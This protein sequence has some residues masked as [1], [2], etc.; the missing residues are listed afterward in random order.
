MASQKARQEIIVHEILLPLSVLF[1][2]GLGMFPLVLGQD[3][4]S[5][6]VILAAHILGQSPVGA[7]MNRLGHAKHISPSVPL[8]ALLEVDL[9]VSVL[10]R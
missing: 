9:E 5:A 7:A 3:Q 1:I 6:P 10:V 8:E 4:I 2:Q